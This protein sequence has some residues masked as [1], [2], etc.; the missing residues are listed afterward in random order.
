MAKWNHCLTEWLAALVIWGDD[1]VSACHGM[2]R[3]WAGIAFVAPFSSLF[4]L[5]LF[6][7]RFPLLSFLGSVT[8]ATVSLDHPAFLPSGLPLSASHQQDF[9]HLR[10]FPLKLLSQHTHTKLVYSSVEVCP[11]TASGAT[12]LALGFLLHTGTIFH[13]RGQQQAALEQFSQNYRYLSAFL[14]S[15]IA[16]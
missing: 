11:D 12:R 16:W 4:Q 8:I 10:S 3:H 9:T 7:S 15:V 6:N 13:A 14:G 2:H 1:C 5:F